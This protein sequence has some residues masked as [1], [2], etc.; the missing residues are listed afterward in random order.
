MHLSVSEKFFAL[1]LSFETKFQ[2]WLER[3]RISQLVSSRIS[4][5]HHRFS[6]HD[7]YLILQAKSNETCCQFVCQLACILLYGHKRSWVARFGDVFAEQECIAFKA[8]QSTAAMII[9]QQ[10]CIFDSK[11]PPM[12]IVCSSLARLLLRE[13]LLTTSLF[14]CVVQLRRNRTFSTP[15]D[16]KIEP[17]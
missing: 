8:K 4:C 1:L 13:G 2:Q 3:M 15:S 5:N 16:G 11:L 17:R 6:R 14:V 10:Y 12:F 9:Q 7:L